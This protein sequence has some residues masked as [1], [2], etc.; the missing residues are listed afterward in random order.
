MGVGVRMGVLGVSRGVGGVLV[1]AEE[2]DEG[3]SRG[4][5]VEDEEERS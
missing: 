1:A 3:V 2:W 5:A 4:E